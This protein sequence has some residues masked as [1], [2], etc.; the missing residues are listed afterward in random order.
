MSLTSSN[1]FSR[2][3]KQSFGTRELKKGTSQFSFWSTP[4]FRPPSI[5]LFGDPQI[6]SVI[7]N[8]NLPQTQNDPVDLTGVSNDIGSANGYVFPRPAKIQQGFKTFGLNLGKFGHLH[9]TGAFYSHHEYPHEIRWEIKLI[10]YRDSRKKHF[11]YFWKRLFFLQTKF[12]FC[13]K[14]FKLMAHKRVVHKLRL[15]ATCCGKCQR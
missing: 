6:T 4:G 13:D 12:A 11:V 8:H 14:I 2:F 1:F 3:K 10:I 5:G 7:N 9:G 15:A